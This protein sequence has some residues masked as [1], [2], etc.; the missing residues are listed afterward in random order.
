M[1]NADIVSRR[2]FSGCVGSNW[3]L[4]SLPPPAGV[5][6][7]RGL[8][9][10]LRLQLQLLLELLLQLELLL[11]P[12]PLVDLSQLLLLLLLVGLVALGRDGRAEPVRG[13]GRAATMKVPGQN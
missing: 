12:D 10:L 7:P 2:T 11:L 13:H 1:K 3:K 4:F 9:P 6:T 5:A 8:R